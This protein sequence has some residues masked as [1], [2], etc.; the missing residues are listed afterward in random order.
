[1]G[2][3]HDKLRKHKNSPRK[4]SPEL[5]NLIISEAKKK[6]SLDIAVYFRTFIENIA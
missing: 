3:L 4:T 6:L 2:P 1:M 5:E